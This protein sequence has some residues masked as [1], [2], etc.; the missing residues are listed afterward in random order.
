MGRLGGEAELN[1]VAVWL[2]S[3][4]SGFVTG[5]EILVDVKIFP[6]FWLYG[7]FDANFCRAD[8]LF[9]DVSAWSWIC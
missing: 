1:G 9:I 2:G 3:E 7:G 8:T 4:A 5:A 6:L